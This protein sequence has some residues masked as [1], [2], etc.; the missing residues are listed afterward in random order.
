M[1]KSFW[2][3][4]G[5]DGVSEVNALGHWGFGSK[6]MKIIYISI[7]NTF[8]RCTIFE[9]FLHRTNLKCFQTL[10]N[11]YLLVYAK[12]VSTFACTLRN[13]CY[14]SIEHDNCFVNNRTNVLQFLRVPV[15]CIDHGH[16]LAVLL[17]LLG[18]MLLSLRD[19]L[20]KTS[21]S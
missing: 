15:L 3:C 20:T 16:M 4:I 6:C 11:D 21:S 14:E 13:N 12:H 18:E 17:G 19:L 1:H 2:R 10:G 9:R 8:L 5:A 7:I